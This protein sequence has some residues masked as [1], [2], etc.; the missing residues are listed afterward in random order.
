MSVMEDNMSKV[1]PGIRLLIVGT[2]VLAA[3]LTPLACK[4][5]YGTT[6]TTTQSSSLSGNSVSISNFSFSPATLNVTAGTKVT[7]TNN[8][9]V[10]H[11]VT[12]DTGSF[13]SGNLSSGSSFSQTFSAAGTFPYHCGIHTYMK[14][15]IIVK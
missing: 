5:G 3:L 13:D 12:S 11:T 14:A 7:W 2:L 15:T 6:S 10:T 1:M 9:S 8:D 4:S